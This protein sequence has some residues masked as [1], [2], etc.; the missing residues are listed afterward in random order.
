MTGLILTVASLVILIA[1]DQVSKYFISQNLAFAQ[2]VTI[3]PGFLEFKYIHNTGISF[4]FFKDM[5][6]IVVAV[7]SIVIAG[8][9]YYLLVKK[10]Q[11]ALLKAAIILIIAGGAGNLADRVIF[12]YVVDFLLFPLDWF[13]FVFNVAD[14]Y[15]SVGGVLLFFYL[16]LDMRK[17]PAAPVVMA[18]DDETVD[19][20]GEQR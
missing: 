12:G 19:F 11:P 6:W 14:C 3:I 4:G 18:A 2:P 15:V 8:F 20:N 17:K 10:P 13:P 5:R 1:G 16:L 9:L 7:T